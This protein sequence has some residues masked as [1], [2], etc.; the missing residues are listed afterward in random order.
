LVEKNPVYHSFVLLV[1]DIEKS[2]HFY[3]IILGQKIVMD[4]GRN[5]GFEGGLAIWERDYALNLI[6]QEKSRDIEVGANN[7]EIYFES[8]NLVGLYKRL[9][10]EVRI[11]HLIREH[12]WGQRAFRVHDPDNHI[13]EFA[14]SMES[15]V[16]R[17]NMQG[18]SLEEIAKKSMMPM[19]FISMTLKKH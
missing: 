8:Q 10:G 1:K 12:P 19:E 11:I 7:A 17:L 16:L 15:V 13:L 2:K 18:L 3:N 9:V 5:V 14:E 4:F 6:F